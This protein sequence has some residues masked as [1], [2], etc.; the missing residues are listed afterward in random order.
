M[1]TEVKLTAISLA[2]NRSKAD[3]LQSSSD[4]D[5]QSETHFQITVDNIY[6]I[7]EGNWILFRFAADM[8]N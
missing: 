7:L 2:V 3:H 1:N 6:L 8:E 5:D 4:K